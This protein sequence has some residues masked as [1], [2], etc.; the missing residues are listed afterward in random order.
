LGFAAFLMGKW[1]AIRLSR[2]TAESS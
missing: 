2:S 1:G